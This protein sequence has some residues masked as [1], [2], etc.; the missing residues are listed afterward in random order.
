[1]TIYTV[2]LMAFALFLF[3]IA[4]FAVALAVGAHALAKM[5]D[6]RRDL[7]EATTKN[8]LHR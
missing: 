6:S 4:T 7:I 1:M 5:D 2:L 3:G 8:G